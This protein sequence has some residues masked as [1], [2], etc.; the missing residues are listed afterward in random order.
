[1]FTGE[2]GGRR[3][4]EADDQLEDHD[5]HEDRYAHVHVEGLPADSDLLGV[6]RLLADAERRLV[7]VALELV[8]ETLRRRAVSAARAWGAAEAVGAA[9]A[10]RAARPGERARR[11]EGRPFG[12]PRGGGAARRGPPRARPRRVTHQLRLGLLLHVLSE[13]PN[14][15]HA[16]AEPGQL[17]VLCFHARLRKERSWG[18]NAGRRGRRR[19]LVVPRRAT[20]WAC[21]NRPPPDSFTPRA[22][23]AGRRMGSPQ[24]RDEGKWLS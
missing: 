16:L 19:R 22:D 4:L 2:G 5:E 21:V 15:V 17:V 23:V 13:A 1:M 11:G 10:G 8:E 20:S 6:L 18:R 9:R 14:P 3:S 12:S 24:P 7:D